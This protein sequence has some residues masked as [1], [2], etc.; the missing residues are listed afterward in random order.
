MC[1]ASRLRI[2]QRRQRQAQ[3]L[4]RL[5]RC[6][7]AHHVACSVRVESRREPGRAG[8]QRGEVP[9]LAHA[10]HHRGKRTRDPVESRLPLRHGAGRSRVD[11][12]QA[13]RGGS[14]G[15]GLEHHPLVAGRV[16]QRDAAF[17][18]KQ[19]LH[20]RPV[21]RTLPQLTQERGRRA[22]AR[23]DDG[24]ALRIEQT[25]LDGSRDVG[26]KTVG[27]RGGVGEDVLRQAF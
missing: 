5:D 8:K 23:D 13:V 26:G 20:A 18:R 11:R 1:N 12:P 10:Q 21:E 19:D 3:P 7:A 27:E 6:D 22:A 16:R 15:E 25:T 24:D 14:A 9:V 2:E 17:V 4:A